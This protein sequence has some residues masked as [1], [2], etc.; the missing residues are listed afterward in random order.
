VR[1]VELQLDN[2]AELHTMLSMFTGITAT[3]CDRFSFWSPVVWRFAGKKKYLR[4]FVESY[5]GDEVA[6]SIRYRK[7]EGK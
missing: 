1:E 5:W 2:P 7:V 4:L 6:E 3:A